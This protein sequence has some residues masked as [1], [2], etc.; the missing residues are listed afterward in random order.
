MLKYCMLSSMGERMGNQG[1]PCLAEGFC[2]FVLVGGGV[3]A[4][5]PHK[6][7]TC[8][9]FLKIIGILYNLRWM[10]IKYNSHLYFLLK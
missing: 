8:Q 6:S 2:P 9:K 7:I 5:N 3:L 10:L 4:P 1:A